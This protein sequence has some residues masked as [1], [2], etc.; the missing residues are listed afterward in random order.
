VLVVQCTGAYLEVHSL[1]YPSCSA[2]L[3]EIF[4]IPLGCEMKKLGDGIIDSSLDSGVNLLR[5]E[6]SSLLPLL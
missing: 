1:M 6:I 5:K 3:G 4:E 2:V